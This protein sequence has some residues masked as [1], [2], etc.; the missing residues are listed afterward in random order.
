MKKIIAKSIITSLFLIY[1]V[2]AESLLT[3]KFEGSNANWVLGQSVSW[4]ISTNFV[5]T[6]TSSLKEEGTGFGW[7]RQSLMQ[8]LSTTNISNLSFYISTS[9]PSQTDVV[10]SYS[11]GSVQL[12]TFINSGTSNWEYKNVTPYL[13]FNKTLI[14]IEIYTYKP[15]NYAS[16]TYTTFYDTFNIQTVPEPSSV[17][18]I[19]FGLF[20]LLLIKNNLTKKK[21]IV[22]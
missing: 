12:N 15:N 14:E 16:T 10:L 20:S 13:A 5:H 2:S 3:Y 17:S 9:I 18:L 4:S 6:G 11:D 19:I 21:S 8:T 7:M 22:E 1:N